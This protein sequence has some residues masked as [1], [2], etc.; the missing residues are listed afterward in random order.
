M[1]ESSGSLKNLRGFLLAAVFAAIV[2]LIVSNIHIFGNVLLVLLGFGGVVLV[3]FYAT[4][5]S[6]PTQD[7]KRPAVQ[8]AA[9]FVWQWR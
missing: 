8:S 6:R 1:S 7:R 2:Y 3:D 4:D 5:A 9:K